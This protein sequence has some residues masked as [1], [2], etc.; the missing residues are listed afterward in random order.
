MSQTVSNFILR[1]IPPLTLTFNRA[2][3]RQYIGLK[4]A[5]QLIRWAESRLLNFKRKLCAKQCLEAVV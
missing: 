2:K 3:V 1:H 5:G 4:Q